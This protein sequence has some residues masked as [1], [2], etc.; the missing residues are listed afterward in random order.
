VK[1][2]EIKALARLLFAT[3][4]PAKTKHQVIRCL[5]TEDKLNLLNEIRI[6]KNDCP[7][8]K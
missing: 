3:T 6:L 5:P 1:E 8:S 4:T 2:K 7:D